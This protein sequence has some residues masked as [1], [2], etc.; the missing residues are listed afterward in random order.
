MDGLNK[1]KHSFLQKTGYI[2]S[3]T[4]SEYDEK[5]ARYNLMKKNSKETLKHIKTLHLH[6]SALS[7]TLNLLSTDIKNV[8]GESDAMSETAQQFAKICDEIE[9]KH[10]KL[11][12]V[13]LQEKCLAALNQMTSED[14]QKM[15]DKRDKAKMAYEEKN[16][17]VK[18]LTEKPPK[19]SQNLPKIK[20][21]NK[22]LRDDYESI[23]SEVKVLFDETFIRDAQAYDA[24]FIGVTESTSKVL[25]NLATSFEPI[26]S[27]A[28]EIT[29]TRPS[30]PVRMTKKSGSIIGSSQIP[31][32]DFSKNYPNPSAE[33]EKS[34]WYYLD[35]TTSQQGPLTWK[36]L[37]DLYQSKIISSATYIYGGEL[38]SWTPISANI[39]VLGALSME[40]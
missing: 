36:Q 25:T 24:V 13:Q 39:A 16:S 31:K 40:F 30:N 29:K 7:S 3:T 14:V 10:L 20:E 34:E 17:E 1:L 27:A 26:S 19:D 22:L 33:Y 15:M 32:E 21:Q 38:E 4:D 35:K 23:S 8:Y 28:E 6:F 2:E 5:K 18:R 37:K 11:F 9:S 12:E